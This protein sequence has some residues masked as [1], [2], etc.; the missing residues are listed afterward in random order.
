M[1]NSYYVS[2]GF[3]QISAKQ[4]FGGDVSEDDGLAGA[5]G[6]ASEHSLC[7]GVQSAEEAPDEIFLIGVRFFVGH[8]FWMRHLNYS[9]L[10]APVLSATKS[11]IAEIFYAISRDESRIAH[12]NKTIL[13]EGWIP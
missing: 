6:H 13:Q 9:L 12:F 10:T 5:G 7:A 8:G 3:L 1:A 11:E 4:K 2:K